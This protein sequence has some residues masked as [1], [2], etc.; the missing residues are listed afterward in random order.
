MVYILACMYMA[1]KRET[2]G[3]DGR[4]S[5]GGLLLIMEVDRRFTAAER[6]RMARELHDTLTL[7]S[8]KQ[9]AFLVKHE[10]RHI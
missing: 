7:A 3:E 10:L 9:Q 8:H 5:S 6:Q 2:N 4:F 1:V